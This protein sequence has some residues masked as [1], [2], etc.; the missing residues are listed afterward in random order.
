MAWMNGA[1]F[2]SVLSA[3]GPSLPISF[4]WNLSLIGVFLG[5]VAPVAFEH[6]LGRA[7]LKPPSA[8]A[9]AATVSASTVAILLLSP[10]DSALSHAVCGTAS[11]ATGVGSATFYVSWT[12][13]YASLPGED[14]EVCIPLT[15]ALAQLIALV[16]GWV[17]GWASYA[18]L[19]LCPCASAAC[20]LLA[21][22]RLA[23]RGSADAPAESHGGHRSL[24]DP[25]CLVF[26]GSVWFALSVVTSLVQTGGSGDF[27]DAFLAPFVVSFGVL[28]ALMLLYVFHA[29]RITPL[30]SARIVVPFIVLGVASLTAFGT[31]VAPVAFLVVRTAAMFYW[32]LLQISVA[33]AVREGVF[34]AAKAI[35]LVRGSI[36]TGAALSIPIVMLL[37]TVELGTVAFFLV[38]LV[39]VAFSVAL[40]AMSG[41]AGRSDEP[42][43]HPEDPQ[44]EEP[45]D[46]E[47]E[48]T[49][50]EGDFRRR[51]D[52]L[53][54]EYGPSP[55]ELDV[56]ICLLH[57]RNMPYIREHL[58]ISRN[59]INTH[60][61]H[62]YAK[63]DV[64]SK[65]E[66]I[67]IFE[68]TR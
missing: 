36:Q 31:Q 64:H 1:F 27:L 4:F 34:I 48:P 16:L 7:A 59:T 13:L 62:I 43:G 24:F 26:T 51:C 2:T 47:G 53:A 56:A 14:A 12:Q 20:L 29:R 60:V 33:D 19:I 23:Q 45:T 67:D 9:G 44:S 10:V 11:L 30:E 28:L 37:G 42:A 39:C 65:Q 8:V 3:I 6:G 66:L 68:S 40:P 49:F 35:G 38:G 41:T 17:G 58:C 18:V 61:R 5:L 32:A 25:R 57:G 50:A 63:L 46:G 54:R 21:E 15:V 52:R 22:A 55:R